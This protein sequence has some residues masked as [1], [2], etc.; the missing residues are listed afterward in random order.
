MVTFERLGSDIFLFKF[1]SESITIT[2][3]MQLVFSDSCELYF[4]VVQD[5]QMQLRL[6]CIQ[7]KYGN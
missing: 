4:S 2:R 1:V 6:F 7:D 5:P 3:A